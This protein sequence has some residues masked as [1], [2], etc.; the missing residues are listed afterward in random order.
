MIDAAMLKPVMSMAGLTFMVWVRLYQVRIPEMQRRRIDPQSIAGSAAKAAT[1]QDT[2]AS[3]N[4]SNLFEM[5]VLFYVAAFT[6]ILAGM[7]TPVSLGLAWTYVG[8]R[9]L[10]SL[11]QCTYNRVMHRFIVYA[12]SSLTLLALWAYLALYGLW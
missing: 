5:P 12:L 4:F 8:L 6:A 11:I 2:R 1:L 3:D 7:V 10:H 9:A